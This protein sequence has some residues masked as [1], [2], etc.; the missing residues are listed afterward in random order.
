M[1]S[2]H[3]HTFLEKILQTAICPNCKSKISLRE[4]SIESC[5]AQACAFKIHC[6]KCDHRAVAQAVIN[7]Q[8]KNPT[9]SQL[10][11]ADQVAQLTPPPISRDEVNF[12]E[13]V[14]RNQ[15]LIAFDSIFPK[16]IK[17]P[18]N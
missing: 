14:F 1:D 2:N 3:L 10:A 12:L 17:L 7:A 6:E 9:A 5:T 11:T 18:R 13:K 15:S 4:I 16:K 8:P